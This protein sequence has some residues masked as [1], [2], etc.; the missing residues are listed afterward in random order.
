MSACMRSLYSSDQWAPD[1]CLLLSCGREMG[2]VLLSLG[3]FRAPIFNLSVT[4]ANVGLEDEFELFM[5]LSGTYC[6]LLRGSYRR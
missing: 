4:R 1:F 5:Q 6:G 2:A 3:D